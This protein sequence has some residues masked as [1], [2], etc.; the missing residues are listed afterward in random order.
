M[1]GLSSPICCS[2]DTRPEPNR[3]AVRSALQRLTEA[4]FACLQKAVGERPLQERVSL[5]A[6]PIPDCV[7][8]ELFN[9]PTLT[10]SELVDA[11]AASRQSIA[12]LREFI[13]QNCPSAFAG[14]EAL[15]E[16]I[17]EATPDEL[18]ARENVA[19]DV[20]RFAADPEEFERLL[21]L[22]QREISRL[23]DLSWLTC[24]FQLIISN[25]ARLTNLDN[26]RDLPSLEKLDASNCTGLTHL[27]GLHNLPHLEELFL[28]GCNSLHCVEG[29]HNLPGLRRL[30]LSGCTRLV[31]IE[32]LR[33]LPSLEELRLTGCTGLTHLKGLPK[34]RSLQTLEL[35]NC[36]GLRG[37]DDLHDLPGLQR[38]NLSHCT[39]LG[40]LGRMRNLPS[41]EELNLFNC[42]S[43][44][45][46]QGLQNFQS[47]RSLELGDCS[48]LTDFECLR[49][50]PRLRRVNLNRCSHFTSIEYMRDLPSLEELF[51]GE[52][53]GLHH[54]NGLQNFPALKTLFL[55]GCRRLTNLDAL[56][57]L[58]SLEEV[59]LSQCTRLSSVK[60][61]QNLPR[62]KKISLGECRDL[63]DIDG[64]QNLP[65]LQRVDL[66]AVPI[67]HVGPLRNLPHLQT[68]VCEGCEHLVDLQ[69][70]QGLP[71]L[72]KLLLDRCEGLTDLV[73]LQDLPHLEFLR[74]TSCRGLTT[75][76][77]LRNVPALK[78]VIL[79]TST[80]LIDIEALRH[81]SRLEA[82]G[83]LGCVS[84]THI[85]GIHDLPSLRILN[86]Y[87]CTNL[88][89]LDGVR[90]LPS[91]TL[92]DLR[93]CPRMTAE[94]CEELRTRLPAN[95]MMN[96]SG[97]ALHGRSGAA[98]R[99]PN[100]HL[101][102]VTLDR[103][104]REFLQ[105]F[106]N[107]LI[108]RKGE[109]PQQWN[110]RLQGLDR[111]VR[112]HDAG[113]VRRDVTYRLV[114]NLFA[115]GPDQ[116]H[117]FG[118]IPQ[119]RP[120]AVQETDVETYRNLGRV[121]YI[122]LRF[123]A[124]IG[125]LLERA[126]FRAL[127]IAVQ[128]PLHLEDTAQ[129][130]AQV[131]SMIYQDQLSAELAAQGMA[132]LSDEKLL[133]LVERLDEVSPALAQ[134]ARG[135]AA[136]VRPSEYAQQ[137]RET[138]S[139]LLIRHPQLGEW[140]QSGMSTL[141]APILEQL[142]PFLER[143]D[144]GLLPEL[145]I[146]L[147]R[148][149]IRLEK[150]QKMS[151]RTMAQIDAKEVLSNLDKLKRQTLVKQLQ[152]TP[153][154]VLPEELRARIQG[155]LQ[156]QVQMEPDFSSLM[157]DLASGKEQRILD[158]LEQW[159]HQCSSYQAVGRAIQAMAAGLRDMWPIHE[160]LSE[161]T[162]ER[163]LRDLEGANTVEE[164]KA[165]CSPRPDQLGD[166]QTTRTH[167]WLMRWIE[168]SSEEDRKAFCAAVTGSGALVRHPENGQPPMRV[169][170]SEQDPDF[171]PVARTCANML[172]LPKTY[173]CY[174]TLKQ[175]LE[176]LIYE[177]GGFG[178]S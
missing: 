62:L 143:Q 104:P 96:L 105:E 102:E 59:N 154:L 124:P 6:E 49:D 67:S 33:D 14:A 130:R 5:E 88:V 38:I 145:D 155:A 35:G 131:A 16:Y 81:C 146:G 134:E 4:Q 150:S 117:H 66:N 56:R 106:G 65:N 22:S 128:D 68:L 50:L 94:S 103:R 26:L 40:H 118:E 63:L 166:P 127:S 113:G 173:P 157:L 100:F 178:F 126:V 152:A 158:G 84:L 19:K 78:R 76:N 85:G 43:F 73:G 3:P 169:V 42:S 60:A 121:L 77:G 32:P 87:R 151:Q 141:S 30:N 9:L 21:D 98:Q 95:C 120:A 97:P 142:M 27:E 162:P 51:L 79:N 2:S 170:F 29:L 93:E 160:N 55:Q 122:P 114:R 48:D 28:N 90:N 52:C 153:K 92:V 156:R 25:C 115:Q 12:R 159:A 71:A 83:L 119:V 72:N 172:E 111:A 64:L 23:P 1:S 47:L 133:Q 99:S 41:L 177:G 17:E 57:D 125:G 112:A 167:A 20:A 135:F 69:G 74:V 168:A 53:G 44:H 15:A 129:A 137:Q 101:S 171:I 139:Y 70:L 174:E 108:L 138:L 132:G 24:S 75:L 46:L 148:E 45:H 110:F 80:E 37:L 144:P 116:L 147:S 36:T 10:R 82:L 136:L 175:K 107:E 34:L 149:Q 13:E 176:L 18:Q 123:P 165:C 8:R 109:P 140:L 54:L 86:L 164:L 11:A 163:L 91:L 61:L 58:P 161:L 39:S 7:L 31:S 89:D